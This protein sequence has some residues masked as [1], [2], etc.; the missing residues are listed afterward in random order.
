MSE[1]KSNL[2][3]D[4]WIEKLWEWADENNIEL[5][6]DKDELLNLKELDL[7][8]NELKELK[9]EVN[10]T[11]LH[12]LLFTRK[13]EIKLPVEIGNLTKLEHLNLRNNELT[14]LQETIMKLTKFVKRNQARSIKKIKI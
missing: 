10:F 2:E 12:K 1:L 11:N 8:Y 14:E 9:E 7:S 13:K 3:N 5:P 6:K 4:S